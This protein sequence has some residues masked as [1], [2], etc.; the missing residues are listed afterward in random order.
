MVAVLTGVRSFLIVV[1]I[2]VSLM[3]S[4]VEQLLLSTDHLHVLRKSVCSGPWPVYFNQIAC[5]L[6]VELCKVFI[7][8]GYEPLIRCILAGSLTCLFTRKL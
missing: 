2:C 8:F 4:D 3:I 6:G 5:F 7:Y 1:L